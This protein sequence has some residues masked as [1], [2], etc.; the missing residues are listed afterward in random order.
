[1]A[2]KKGKGKKIPP[3]TTNNSLRIKGHKLAR[4]L[5]GASSSEVLP[6]GDRGGPGS[7]QA[8]N[9]DAAGAASTVFREAVGR[10]HWGESGLT[11][12]E[13][14]AGREDRAGSELC[15]AGP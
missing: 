11:L 14:P 2:N 1:M 3:K 5:T 10:C 15:T 4:I 6:N 7:A 8:P 13:T 12:G 9:E